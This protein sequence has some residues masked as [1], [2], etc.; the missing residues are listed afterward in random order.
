MSALAVLVGGALGA[1]LRYALTF[2]PFLQG[3]DDSGKIA[4]FPWPTFAAN[5][6]ASFVLGIVIRIAG[7]STTEVSEMIVAF[8]VVGMCGALSTMSTFALELFNL[9]RQKATVTAV[10]YLTLSL[11]AA[12]AAMWLGLLVAA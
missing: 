10:G 11:G 6:L 2:A 3:K 12:M 5:V 4:R 7:S 1:L 8:I 9:M